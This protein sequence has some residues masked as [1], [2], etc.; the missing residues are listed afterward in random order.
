M[1]LIQKSSLRLALILGM[2]GTSAQAQIRVGPTQTLVTQPG[3]TVSFASMTVVSQAT[4]LSSVTV[5]GKDTTGYSIKSSSGIYLAAGCLR[6]G[7]GTVQCSMASGSGV[8]KSSQ[9]VDF[10]TDDFLSAIDGTAT[11]FALSQIP[12]STGSIVVVLNGLSLSINHDF[13]YSGGTIS[14][15]SAPALTANN[16]FAQ[17]AMNTTVTP[18]A[19]ALLGNNT[20]SGVNTFSNST[21]LNGGITLNGA[22]TINTAISLSSAPN[23]GIPLNAP[24]G[25]MTLGISTAVYINGSY[26]NALS[27]DG[28]AQSA[29]CAVVIGFSTNA[30]NG[31]PIFSSTT[32]VRTNM[33]G[34]LLANCAPGAVCPVGVQG[35]FRAR[36]GSLLNSVGYLD[37]LTTDNLRCR[38][39]ENLAVNPYGSS[40][41]AIPAASANT[42][43]VLAGEWTPVWIR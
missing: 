9:T 14:L 29:G 7:D 25:N 2:I 28:A 34:V 13:T 39:T 17:Y 37:Y 21:I 10:I 16:F 15:A 1:N 27:M 22:L 11:D 43:H 38:V 6:F 3:M 33:V 30:L 23:G 4:F 19:P 35:V 32:T 5:Q 20:F 12:T 24:D 42:V 36:A 18:G 41:W 31:H 26:I 40:I 8:A